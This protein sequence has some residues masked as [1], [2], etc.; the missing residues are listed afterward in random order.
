MKNSIF[1]ILLLLSVSILLGQNRPKNLVFE[2]AGIRGIAYAGVIN[3]LESVGFMDGIEKV[4][5]TS[6]GAITA[7]FIAL[8]YKSTEIQEIISNT[9]FKEFNDGQYMF[10]G[11]ISR[12]KETYGWYRHNEF[13]L[14]LEKVIEN[15]TGN[16]N[17]TFEELSKKGYRDLYTISTCLNKQKLL[18]FSEETY[19]KM[20]IKDA[21]IASM[22]IPL[23]FE[24]IF[25]DSIGHRYDKQNK[26]NNLDVVV[27]GGILGNFPIFLF[28]STYVD[29]LGHSTRIPNPYTIGIRIDTDDQIKNDSIN[30]S[31]VEIP[32]N[33]L[34]TY[35]ISFYNI[36]LENLNR[37][38]LTDQDWIRS[39][40]V[41]S[42]G[43]GPRI[44][45]LSEEQKN[46]L[47]ESGR[48]STL[49]YLKI[50]YGI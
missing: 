35:V 6:A 30:Q 24:A 41:S 43:I 34:T 38:Q 10:V 40:S 23:Y 13:E 19:P 26:E 7:L 27:D 12:F 2:G 45:K 20:R 9:N 29:S 4:G 15:K 17:I 49:K 16:A 8:D 48:K 11:G 25:I 28:D 36:I 33:D 47:V 42:V 46:A 39:I 44:K 5:G 18:V 50:N 32:I 37:P 22:S 31:L 14:W 1:T 3:Q 21:V